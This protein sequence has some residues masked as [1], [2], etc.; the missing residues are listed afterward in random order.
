MRC[1]ALTQAGPL[2]LVFIVSS[3]EV[4]I[5]QCQSVHGGKFIPAKFLKLFYQVVELLRRL[6]ERFS[7]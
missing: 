2:G 5:S 1:E 3:W 6:T 7:E 4:Q